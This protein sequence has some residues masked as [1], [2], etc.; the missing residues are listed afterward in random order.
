[1][2]KQEPEIEL[3]AL[4]RENARLKA[5]LA[6]IRLRLPEHEW[7]LIREELRHKEAQLRSVHELTRA[8]PWS[9][10]AVNR[11][12]D[13]PLHFRQAWTAFLPNSKSAMAVFLSRVHKN[14][15]EN[16]EN[17]W[18]DPTDNPELERNYRYY[19]DD[20]VLRYFSCKGLC[21]FDVSGKKVIKVIGVN[22]EITKQQRIEKEL[23]HKEAQLRNAYELAN[24]SAWSY[25]FKKDQLSPSKQLK[26][27]WTPPGKNI[28]GA[29]LERIRPEDR[30]RILDILGDSE[31]SSSFN[32]PYRITGDDGNVY[33]YLCRC[34]IE[35][36]EQG[37]PTKA[38]GVAWNITERKQREKQTLQTE[39]HLRF[40]FEKIGLGVWEYTVD[41]DE[42]Y[43]NE[44]IRLFARIKNDRGIVK[45]EDLFV[46][47]HFQD[48]DRVK[49]L[50]KEVLA[51][52]N[53]VFDCTFRL[54]RKDNKYVWIL[55]R[56]VSIFDDKSEVH[57][58]IGSI[59][60][61]SQSKRY[62]VIKER[63]NF[64]QRIADALPIPIYYKNLKGAYVGY[65]EAFR[66][67]I[68]S[69]GSKAPNIIGSTVLDIHLDNNEQVGTEI[70]NDEK[71]FL[72]NPCEN[73]EKIYVLNTLSGDA[74]III[75]KKSILYD[76]DDKPKY[77]VGGVLDV[78][79][80]KLAEERLQK[81]TKRL[82]TTLNAMSEIIMCF[83]TNL[84]LQWANRA[85]RSALS[86]ENKRFAG[87][88]WHKIWEKGENLD[89]EEHPV[90]KVLNNSE[91]FSTRKMKT[92]DGR[93]YEVR[94]YPV[95]SQ[96]RKVTSVVETS[97]DITEHEAIKNKAEIRK[98]QLVLADKMKSLGVLISG[99]AHEINNPNNSININI[100]LLRKMW[101][102]SK[103]FFHNKM[104]T[105]PGFKLG[106]IP[107]D[108]LEKSMDDLLFGIKDGSER[109][110]RIIDSL[111]SY[112][113]NV[114]GDIKETFNL[115]DAIEN[116]IFLLKNQILKATNKFT[117]NRRSKVLLVKGV[118]QKIEQVI[119]N[120]L[121]NACQALTYREQSIQIE[122]SIDP[123]GE[124]AIIKVADTGIGIESQNLN[125]IT[126]PF[127]TTRREAGGTGLGLSI[128]SSILEDH[129]GR[130]SFSSESGMGTSVEIILPLLADVIV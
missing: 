87:R 61:L 100:T 96:G 3:Q 88:K 1:M 97:L 118:Q 103:P 90:Y 68:R 39:S 23:L 114:P 107:G 91:D 86:G 113:R 35:R 6:E 14:D 123:T 41:E 58:V 7:E 29:F 9:Y 44:T 60:D 57:K 49:D 18:K 77:L 122:T 4:C 13:G 51:G 98:E 83:D 70:D 64:M 108:K 37:K 42:L 73:F 38:H 74:R 92:S 130:F 72:A 52:K 30:D 94:A 40:F 65:N 124:W 67:F 24:I 20:G 27:V 32:F 55:A 76:S 84:T 129:K 127:F 63:L 105:A 36:D 19:D 120:V 125:Y 99:V 12:L 80:L 59:E 102:D 128:S 21:I 43:L 56:G 79:G 53:P 93:I 85:A 17:F 75:N 22:Q 78:T 11:K 33:Y 81:I 115:N 101:E 117:V 112:I 111:K 121:Q 8:I 50:F 95:R 25:D 5:E 119:I 2:Q 34:L 16:I 10:D 26:A 126:D 48:L 62:N 110:G 15:R 89:S 54:L 106:N 82:N 104:K 66:E 46:R 71:D 69:V 45:R 109:I 28:K 116:A 47:I 31:K